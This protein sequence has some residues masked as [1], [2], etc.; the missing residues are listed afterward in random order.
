MEI[1]DILLGV[2]EKSLHNI[3]EKYVIEK[4][5]NLFGQYDMLANSYN[6]IWNDKF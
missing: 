1:G 3:M 5:I 2:Q 4:Y 6:Y